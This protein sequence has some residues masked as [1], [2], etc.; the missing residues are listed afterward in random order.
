[1]IKEFCR[2]SIVSTAQ[3][4]LDQRGGGM[5]GGMD[6]APVRAVYGWA[7]VSRWVFLVTVVLVS[8]ILV[9]MLGGLAFTRDSWLSGALI[10]A[11]LGGWL[12]LA[13][14][15]LWR[16]ALTV[17]VAGK[18]LRWSAPLRRGSVPIAEVRAVRPVPVLALGGV[19]AVRFDGGR[20]LWV[21]VSKGFSELL[22]DLREEAGAVDVRLSAAVGRIDRMPGRN[23]YRRIG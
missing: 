19:H 23:Q 21:L 3:N 2:D 5:K 14:L 9:P 17:K 8:A 1:L 11:A 18:G 6:D 7:G 13:V 15:M 20:T 4:F 16:L 10:L 12:L 22:D